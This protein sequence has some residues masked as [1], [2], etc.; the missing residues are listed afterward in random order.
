MYAV[1]YSARFDMP[2][3][4]HWYSFEAGSV[5]FTIMSTEH[6]FCKGSKQYEWIEADLASV[7]RSRT[8]WIVFGGHRPMYIDSTGKLP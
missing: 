8:P 6:D 5:H 3:K 7:N 2:N 4:G 1:P